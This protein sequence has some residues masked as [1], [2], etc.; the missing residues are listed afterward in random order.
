[1]SQHI[2]TL[3]VGD[4]GTL[5]L[6]NSPFFIKHIEVEGKQYDLM[7]IPP[8]LMHKA[9]DVEKEAF[10]PYNFEERDF[11]KIIEEGK[12]QVIGILDGYKVVAVASWVTKPVE[13]VWN[14]PL[15]PHQVMSSGISVLKDYKGFGF[16]Q[17]LF[18]EQI[19]RQFADP[20]I[21]TLLS[22][23]SPRNLLPMYLRFKTGYTL[24]DVLFDQYKPD[25]FAGPHRLLFSYQRTG[26][27]G[28][29][30]Q[31]YDSN[32]TTTVDLNKYSLYPLTEGFADRRGLET[33]KAVIDR[34]KQ[35]NNP[36]PIKLLVRNNKPGERP[37]LTN[38]HL[39]L[40]FVEA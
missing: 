26:R 19:K 40:P 38:A 22:T 32:V 7:A 20:N 34:I 23:V 10:A 28:D 9:A 4:T 14:G 8:F 6:E 25:A 24:E 27:E 36:L 18:Y 11:M 2:P 37:D 21:T 3:K 12:G 33:L 16:G 5:K 29:D 15:E 17:I 1:M 30:Y 13:G 31:S 35:S 39:L